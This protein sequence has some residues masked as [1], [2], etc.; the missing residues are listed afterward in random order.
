MLPLIRAIVKDLRTLGADVLE[1]QHRLEQ[2]GSY[3]RRKGDFHDDEVMAIQASIQSDVERMGEY[4]GE[5]GAL[6]VECKGVLEGLVDFPAWLDDRIVF[7][8][9][10][11]DEPEVRHWH[12]IDG[13]FAG[14]RPVTGL[15]FTPSG[16]FHLTSTNS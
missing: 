4:V 10:K 5:L 2:L 6:G 3:K 9:W 8:C 13:G 7:L 14:R 16:K 12:E 11:L 1:R 15:I